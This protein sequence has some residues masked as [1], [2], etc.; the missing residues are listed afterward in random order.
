M[1]HEPQGTNATTWLGTPIYPMGEVSPMDYIASKQYTDNSS[2]TQI[3]LRLKGI[4][5]QLSFILILSL[6]FMRN[7]RRIL[8][9]F[10][11]QRTALSTWC[12]L[13]PSILGSSLYPLCCAFVFTT[14]FGC[15]NAIWYII[16][17]GTISFVC[18]TIIVVQRAYLASRQQQWVAILGGLLVLPQIG[19]AF[20][21]MYYS[22]I[23]MDEVEGCV[24]HYP[25]FVALY[26]CFVFIPGNAF[27]SGIFSYVAFK[28]YKSYGNG[29]WR[30][31][32]N[33]GI[34]SM[35]LVLVCNIVTALFIIFKVGGEF[36]EV[37]FIVDWLITSVIL[38]NHTVNIRRTASSLVAS[39]DNHKRIPNGSLDIHHSVTTMPSY[40]ALTTIKSKFIQ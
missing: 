22:P 34:Q 2:R 4:Y 15:R 20:V 21:S 18:N 27:L 14:N 19:Y 24:V 16:C 1:A 3:Q 33:D 7:L 32:R 40:F 10:K 39:Y 36:S 25:N 11:K 12:C 13:T 9:L 35:C 17:I 6:I 8:F 38:V 31:L 37:F 30:R 5:F 23:T 29:A 26:W 28:Q